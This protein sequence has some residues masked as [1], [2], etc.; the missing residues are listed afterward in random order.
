MEID[1]C[2]ELDWMKEKDNFE[3]INE[4]FFLFHNKFVPLQAELK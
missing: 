2:V 3:K 1:F 4:K